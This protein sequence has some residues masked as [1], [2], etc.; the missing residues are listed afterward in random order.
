[1]KIGF[2][3]MPPIEEESHLVSDTA[4]NF[5]S[6]SRNFQLPEKDLIQEINKQRESML[7]QSDSFAIQPESSIIHF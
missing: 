1:M 6:N 3:S 7:Q 5:S 2:G 4:S